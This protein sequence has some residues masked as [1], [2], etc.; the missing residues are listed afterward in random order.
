MR[1]IPV[2]ARLLATVLALS[3]MGWGCAKKAISTDCNLTTNLCS[4][5]RRSATDAPDCRD[6][7][8]MTPASAQ[9]K[10]TA[11]GGTFSSSAA[12]TVTN[13][14]GTC[15]A[16]IGTEITYQRFYANNFG[17]AAAGAAACNYVKA[18]CF[19]VSAGALGDAEWSVSQIAGN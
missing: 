19:I 9:S 3:M 5:D 15:K 6:Y 14:L 8:A 18:N 10:C 11:D 16:T 17:D 7:V 1:S 4:C 2:I 12:C 13:L